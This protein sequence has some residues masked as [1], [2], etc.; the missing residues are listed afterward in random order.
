MMF[1]YVNI[2]VSEPTPDD[3]KGARDSLKLLQ[4]KA[5][6]ESD[7]ELLKRQGPGY[8]L[9]NLIPI[10]STSTIDDADNMLETDASDIARLNRYVVAA[11][12]LAIASQ[13]LIVLGLVLFCHYHF[14]NFN[15]G[16]G[17]AT[18]YLML[19]Y[20]AVFTGH[21]LHSLPAALLVWALVC[22]RRP[23]VSG[24]LMGMAIGVSYYPIFLLPLWLSFYWERGVKSFSVGVL[25]S[26][27]VCILGLVF[28]SPDVPFF[29]DRLRGMFGFLLPRLEGLAGIWELGWSGWYRMPL[30][31]ACVALSVSFVSWPPEKNLGTLA[32][33]TAAIMVAV[34]FWM[35]F[36]GGLCMAWYLPIALLVFFRPNLNGRVALV[37]L[38]ESHRRSRA[39]SDEN[40]SPV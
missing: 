8:W 29:L 26:L 13:V 11:K 39:K 7:T 35:G 32:A 31:V 14:G 25:I 40:L 17:T 24:V 30:L 6:D 16:V 22:F 18:I 10:I 15:V 2:I 38:N 27:M 4:R 9:F 5:V 19:P 1:L 23:S 20:T 34:Q 3:L 36:D 37:E 21:A 33:Y 28:T 12:L